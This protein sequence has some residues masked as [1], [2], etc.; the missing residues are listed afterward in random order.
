MAET[1]VRVSALDR[2]GRFVPGRVGR[3]E[4]YV[5]V[6]AGLAWPGRPTAIPGDSCP[7]AAASTCIL[8]YFSQTPV[9]VFPLQCPGDY[10]MCWGL[11]DEARLIIPSRRSVSALIPPVQ[12]V[13]HMQLR[14][15]GDW[16]IHDRSES[17]FFSCGSVFKLPKREQAQNGPGGYG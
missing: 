5:Q 9:N 4:R 14:K 17:F 3:G 10:V 6:H 12:S 11:A 16:A 8:R 15:N 7:R 13:A 1:R 2:S